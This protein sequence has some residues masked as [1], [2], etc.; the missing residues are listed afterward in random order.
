[1]DLCRGSDYWTQE[2]TIQELPG[3]HPF[4]DGIS[5][6][7][8]LTSYLWILVVGAVATF[9]I[10]IGLGTALWALSFASG[11]RDYIGEYTVA[12]CCWDVRCGRRCLVLGIEKCI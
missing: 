3:I 6:P 7:R 8:Q 12:I 4:I 1:M 2:L 10:S 9:W 11:G 5:E